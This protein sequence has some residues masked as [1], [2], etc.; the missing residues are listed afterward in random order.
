MVNT[1][2]PVYFEVVL[3][4]SASLRSGQS[5]TRLFGEAK[6]VKCFCPAAL[7]CL[8]VPATAA[9]KDVGHCLLAGQADTLS[10]HL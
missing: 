2:R 9:R 4:A 6:R 7:L 5:L 3:I 1:A 8:P 10:L